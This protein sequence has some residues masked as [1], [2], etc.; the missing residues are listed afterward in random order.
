MEDP[1]D[2]AEMDIEDEG[3]GEEEGDYMDIGGL[4]TSILTTDEGDTVCSALVTIGK[5][6]EMQNKILVKM[7]SKL[8]KPT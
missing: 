2:D 7:L 6:L 1:E 5:Q 8:T 4:L 3:E